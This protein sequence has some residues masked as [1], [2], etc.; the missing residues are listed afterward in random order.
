MT[1]WRRGL[2]ALLG[3]S[4]SIVMLGC[5]GDRAV[6][7]MGQE[8]LYTTAPET[9]LAEEPTAVP[10]ATPEP[11]PVAL[12]EP[13]TSF[14]QYLD[15]D[16]DGVK[17][18]IE[19][20]YPE[21]LMEMPEGEAEE[22]ERKMQLR[23]VRGDT[24]WGSE[25]ALSEEARLFISDVD[26]DGFSELLLEV[27]LGETVYRLYGWR[28]TGEEL[29]PL[30]FEGEESFAG[31][32]ESLKGKR[33]TLHCW[34]ELLGSHMLEQDW[35]LTEEGFIPDEESWTVLESG[36][37]EEEY[38]LMVLTEFFA[39]AEDE[40]EGVEMLLPQGTKLRITRTDLEDT[41]W[42]ETETGDRGY[43]EMGK[44]A[45]GRFTVFEGRGEAELFGGMEYTG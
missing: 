18:L 13:V 24:S 35:R 19:L 8:S 27:Q 22:I 30:L 21:E 36:L 31:C 5:G 37:G 41:V 15:L 33:L 39:Y 12:E 9:V 23:I 16:G 29:V 44:D 38:P 40:E 25:V 4:M 6:D 26:G 42:F 20:E 1:K 11:V 45:E 43:L 17:E 7:G 14:P 10:T 34:V 3:V 28:F 32:I 2:S